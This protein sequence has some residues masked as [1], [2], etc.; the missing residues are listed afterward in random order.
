MIRQSDPG[1]DARFQALTPRTRSDGA[2]RRVGVE[3]EFGGLTEAE[4]ARI[5]AGMFGGR[6]SGDGEFR[7]VV[8]GS[9]IGDVEVVLDT[10]WRSAAGNR[11][12]ELGLEL[13]RAVV[14]VEIVTEPRDPDMLMP[15]MER[16]CVTL[17]ERGALGSRDGFFLG[18]GVHLNVEVAAMTA[19]A[20]VPVLRAYAFLEDWLRATRPLDPSRRLL[21]FVDPYPRRLVDALADP[22]AA[23]W[24]LPMLTGRYLDLNASRNRGLDMLPIL[25]AI[26]EDAVTDALWDASAV[27][28]RP[29]FHYRLPD[30]RID[31]PDWSLA[32]L[33]NRWCLVERIAADADM[34]DRLAQA[35]RAHR[36][37]LTTLR[38]D[39]ADTVDELLSGRAETDTAPA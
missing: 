29:A 3:I 18:F 20:I 35:W 32:D 15:S 37:S 26:D 24:T 2:P 28:A 12:A 4:V 38:G 31:E 39:W 36:A 33:W 1:D 34:L 23:D 8:E 25:R 16:L 30:S 27:H 19:P 6:I 13:S 14:P 9:A 21:P 22:E 10:A 7:L 11:L 17:R 5:V